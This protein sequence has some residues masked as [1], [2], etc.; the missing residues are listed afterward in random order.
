MSHR[1]FALLGLLALLAAAA[2]G[3][4]EP[5]T[6]PS[7]PPVAPA[8]ACERKAVWP[9]TLGCLQ[10][11]SRVVQAPCDCSPGPENGTCFELNLD[12][13]AACEASV[14]D[15]VLACGIDC[16]CRGRCYEGHE[17]CEVASANLEGC[18]M[19][20]CDPSCE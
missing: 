15:C 3:G 5:T 12:R 17:A 13:K 7:A 10:C 2:C 8:A 16:A 9:S 18:I 11:G 4:A 14:D 20:T 6:I 19:Q 1:A